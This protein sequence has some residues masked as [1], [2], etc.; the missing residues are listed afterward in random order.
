M[1]QKFA[2]L[3]IVGALL[4][5]AIPASSS[6]SMFP[7]SA[8]F[9]VGASGAAPTLGTS[10]GSCVVKIAGQVPKAPENEATSLSFALTPTNFSCTSGTS[11]KFNGEWKLVASNY[12]F[13]LAA[14]GLPSNAVE[15]RSTTLPNCKLAGSFSLGGLYSN[16]TTSPKAMS[17]AMHPHASSSLTWANDGGTCAIAGT[18]ETLTYGSGTGIWTV[19]NLTTPA[20]PIIVAN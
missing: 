12:T 4:A 6:A 11:I 1:K 5:L 18:K 8:K 10:I 14:F 15:F 16:G 13:L 2:L 19:N 3:T 9:E 17:S 20:T 7:A